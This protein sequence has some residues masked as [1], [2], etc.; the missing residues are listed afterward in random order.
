MKTEQLTDKQLTSIVDR[1][2]SQR[3][4]ITDIFDS[5]APEWSEEHIGVKLHDKYNLINSKS[6]L[7]S[8]T[9][10]FDN[11]GYFAKGYVWVELNKKFNFIDTN[12]NYLSP[13]LWFNMVGGFENNSNY[14]YVMIDNK[15][16]WIDLQG[17]LLDNEQMELLG[18]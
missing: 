10:W 12:G 7:V 15:C 9:Q 5:I 4:A 3:K 18:E 1:R 13:N 11:I 17:N 14:S 16:L 8:P 2:L 6:E